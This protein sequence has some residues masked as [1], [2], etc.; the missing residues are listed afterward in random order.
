MQ[1]Q[2]LVKKGL[3]SQ[4]YG[5]SSSHVWLWVLDHKQCLAQKNWC[6]QTVMLE[7][8][9]ESPLD[10]KDIKPGNSKGSQS[11]IFIGRT[12]AE[13]EAPIF[14]LPGVKNWLTGKDP[15]AGK[16]WGQEKGTTEVE[17]VGW[18]H[19][20][21]GQEFQQCSGD[22]KRHR[23]LAC[24]SPWGQK[25]LDMTE[26][27]NSDKKGEQLIEFNEAGKTRI[28]RKICCHRAKVL[29]PVSERTKQLAQTEF[30]LAISWRCQISKEKWILRKFI[31]PYWYSK[32]ANNMFVRK[33]RY[34]SFQ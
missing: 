26:W 8:T 1:G 13:A 7:K 34:K 6:F 21:D 9:L 27:L 15:D 4:S 17:M 29:S 33:K 3:Y 25:E 32:R 14:W 22:G 10:S 19:C 18:S 31:S 16:S 12:D 23:S 28:S 24:C 2:Y 11:C 30:S 5:F 20:L